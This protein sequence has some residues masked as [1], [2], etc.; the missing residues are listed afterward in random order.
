MEALG[1]VLSPSRDVFLGAFLK[2]IS[3]AQIL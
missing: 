2:E 1:H 3:Q